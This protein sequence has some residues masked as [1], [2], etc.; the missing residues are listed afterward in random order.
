MVT[1][2]LNRPGEVWLLFGLTL[3]A[4]ITSHNTTLQLK[5]LADSGKGVEYIQR[6]IVHKT[7]IQVI[8]FYTTDYAASAS[9]SASVRL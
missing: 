9:L 4:N 1:E 7:R 3:C 5:I 8:K 2:F 6:D